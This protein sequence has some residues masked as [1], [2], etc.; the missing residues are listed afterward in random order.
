MRGSS[1][2]FW[3]SY[4]SLGL[5]NSM[6]PIVLVDLYWFIMFIVTQ[7]RKVQSCLCDLHIFLMAWCSRFWI[8]RLQNCFR[9]PSITGP[10]AFLYRKSQQVN[11][12][13]ASRKPVKLADHL[14]PIMA[15][16]TIFQVVLRIWHSLTY[17]SQCISVSRYSHDSFPWYSSIWS[18]P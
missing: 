3:S 5:S 11:S 17:I 16:P 1:A 8:G 14:W 15:A 4:S 18:F 7:T 9:Q 2:S 6:I 13:P 12:H 10:C